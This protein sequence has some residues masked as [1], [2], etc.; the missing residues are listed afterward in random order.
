MPTVPIRKLNQTPESYSPSSKAEII[1]MAQAAAYASDTIVDPYAGGEPPNTA[2]RIKEY[3]RMGVWQNFF[4]ALAIQSIG[5]KLGV[6]RDFG[7]Y[8][9]VFTGDVFTPIYSEKPGNPD[10]LTMDSGVT[11]YFFVPQV[12][13]TAYAAMGHDCIYLSGEQIKK[14]YKATINA[15]KASIDNS[16]PVLIRGIGDVPMSGHICPFMSEGAL[17]GGYDENNLYI[18]IYSSGDPGRMEEGVIDED[19]YTAFPIESVFDKTDGIFFA[20]EKIDVDM[21]QVYRIALEAIPGFLTSPPSKGYVF[22]KQAFDTWVEG[23]LDESFFEGRDSVD[24]WKMHCMAYCT[25]CSGFPMEFLQEVI[26]KY[27]NIT[28]ASKLLP[29]YEKFFGY[30][31][32]IWELQGG[33]EP[34]QEKFLTREF[35][36]ELTDILRKMGE[37][38]DEILAVFKEYE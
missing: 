34:P 10:Y 26:E 31:D 15:V 24:I 36:I 30:K 21:E 11:C 27:P 14:N 18:N 25:L 13:K 5:E 33:F 37:T 28:I 23:L 1:T 38:C 9:A 7:R 22:G 4:L 29:L 35:R 3:K 6:S 12:I 32:A 19:G 2:N 16:I 17:I 8:W 20:G